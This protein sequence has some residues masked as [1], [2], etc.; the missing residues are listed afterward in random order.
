MATTANNLIGIPWV[1]GGATEAGADCWGLVLLAL[2]RIY[3]IKLD[4]HRGAK[5]IGND[6][7]SLIEQEEAGS[8]WEQVDQCAEGVV[9]TLR[10]RAGSRPE[11][12]G[13]GLNDREILHSL[14]S[15]ANGASSVHQVRALDMIFRDIRY[16]RYVGADTRTP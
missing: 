2:D 7:S 5:F 3:G 12:V 9:V 16:Y 15:H 11:H 6:L 1:K 13:V 8:D 4:R 14:H 10:A